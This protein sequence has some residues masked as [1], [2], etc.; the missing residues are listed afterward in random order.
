MSV[1]SILRACGT[2]AAAALLLAWPVAA[3][4]AELHTVDAVLRDSASALGTASLSRLRT[5][6]LRG[7]GTIVGVPAT[8]DT[9]EDL[10]SGASSQFAVAGPLSGAQGFDGTHAWNRD[11]SGVVWNDGS[12][13]AHYG[14]LLGAFQTSLSLWRIDHGGATVVAAAPQTD[15]TRHF[16]V[17]RVTPPGC[18][19]YDLWFDAVTHLPARSI[20]TIGIVT[21]TQKYADYHAVDGVEIPFDVETNDDAGNATSYHAVTA[22]ANPGEASEML[23]RPEMHVDDYSLPGGTTSIPFELVD[24]HVDLPVTINGKGPFHFLFDTGGSNVLDA[25][26]AKALG[27]TAQGNAAGSGV[28]ATTEAIQFATVAALGVGGATLRNQVFAIAPVRAGFGVAS[29]KPIDGLIG[30]EVLARFVTTFDYA[31]GTVVLQTASAAVPHGTTV[32]FFFHGQQPDIGCTIDGIDGRCTV[33]TGSRIGLSV[34]TPFLAVHP[35]IGGPSP[36]AEGADGFGVGGFAMGRLARTTLAL[37]GFFMPDV[38]TDLS[39]QGK[40][41]FADPFTAGNIGATVWKR[42]AVTFDYAKQTMTLQPNASFAE[43]E[44]YDRSGLFLLT[45]GGKIVVGDVRPGTPAALAGIVRGDTITSVD[46]KDTATLDLAAIRTLF[47][48]DPGTAHTLALTGKDGTSRNAVI[49]LQDY[50]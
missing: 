6:H 36:T 48:G 1:P 38:I 12:L 47:R 22:T 8:V 11:A 21:T 25:E 20:A 5:L 13:D 18:Y 46:G 17:L 32:P 16:D 28:G 45:Q 9:Y 14:G 3:P 39:T 4:A 50:V 29:G 33:D 15:G 37:G 40:G 24:N 34:C 7:T 41:A 49:T 2:G 30:F 44:S 31:N 27:L 10:R 26:A 23:Q 42:F 43:R 35:T 19:P